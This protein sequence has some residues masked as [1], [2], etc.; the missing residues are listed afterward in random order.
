MPNY[1][2][3]NARRAVI[4]VVNPDASQKR[5]NRA[6]LYREMEE[7]GIVVDERN[8]VRRNHTLQDG[9]QVSVLLADWKY[10]LKKGILL[11]R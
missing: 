3:T 7:R 11:R 8:V 6:Q 4:Y 9:T 1:T 2:R 5:A 10:D